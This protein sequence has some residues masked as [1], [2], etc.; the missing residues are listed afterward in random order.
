MDSSLFFQKILIAFSLF[1]SVGVLL[2]SSI[3]LYHT[4]K[5]SR[6]TDLSH[7]RTRNCLVASIL[8]LIFSVYLLVQ[9]LAPAIYFIV[10]PPVYG[11][12]PE[13][14]LTAEPSPLW[15]HM[16]FLVLLL[17]GC[18]LYFVV[19]VLFYQLQKPSNQQYFSKKTL[20]KY[21]VMG[22]LSLLCGLY[23]SAFHFW[24]LVRYYFPY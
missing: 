13:E 9:Y 20:V 16:L 2:I 17:F 24:P 18:V 5:R 3:V 4:Y 21:R 15:L 8:G 7:P 19:S 23:L 10:V 1:L 6:L 11:P 12:L 22:A 14:L